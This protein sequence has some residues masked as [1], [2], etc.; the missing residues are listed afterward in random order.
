MQW[1][2]TLFFVKFKSPVSLL[3]VVP[4]RFASYQYLGAHVF[5]FV[6]HLPNMLESKQSRKE[7]EK[8]FNETYIE[9]VMKSLTINLKKAMDFIANDDQQGMFHVY[10]CTLQIKIN[11]DMYRPQ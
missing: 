5:F 2:C 8:T 9:P 1:F 7:W 4:V 10:I 11:L 3:K 6:A